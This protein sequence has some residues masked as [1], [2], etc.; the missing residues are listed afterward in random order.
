MVG[1]GEIRVNAQFGVLFAAEGG[2]AMKMLGTLFVTALA[3]AG[4]VVACSVPVDPSPPAKDPGVRGGAA[5]AGGAIA[6]LTKDEL[7]F[8]N[9][10]KNDFVE[11]ETVPE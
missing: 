7:A 3:V 6:G 9:A 4:V 10:G 1:P 5:G 2:L 11:E 8:F